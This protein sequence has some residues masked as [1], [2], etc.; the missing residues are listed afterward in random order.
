MVDRAL[1]HQIG[2]AS[3]EQEAREPA[4]FA[5]AIGTLDKHGNLFGVQTP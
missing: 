4:R 5:R 3:A 1:L 2:I